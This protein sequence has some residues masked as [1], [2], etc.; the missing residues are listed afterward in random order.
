VNHLATRDEKNELVKA[1]QAL[2]L[3]NDGMLSREELIIGYSKMMPY[4]EA[5]VEVEKIMSQVDKNNSNA[6][7]Y[8]GNL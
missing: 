5:E 2:D 8:T 6:I 4:E 1:F 7:D 3:N